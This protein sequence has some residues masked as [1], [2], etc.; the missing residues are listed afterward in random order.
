M[1]ASSSL[2]SSDAWPYSGSAALGVLETLG[3][4]AALVALDQ[5]LKTSNV[6]VLQAEWNDM[7]GSVIKVTGTTSDV[8][9]A[10][11]AGQRVAA[12]FFPTAPRNNTNILLIH[13]PDREAMRAILSPIEFSPLIEQ[14]VVKIPNP[15]D[16]SCTF[17][18]GVTPPMSNSF[19][20]G[21]IETQGF[22]AIFEA[23]D[24]ACKSAA[25]EVVGKEKLGGGYVT[26]VIKG[27]VAAVNAAV[28]AAKP[29]IEGLG[30]LIA[31]HV[32]ARPSPAAL[33]L[34]PK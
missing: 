19:A 15:S 26:I 23:I 25:V 18:H 5:M 1:N 8:E 11:Q 22:T 10:L 14:A 27:D 31:C 17:T 12:S 9:S 34:L 3:W 4:T 28:E 20:L 30:K 7:L 13:N 29:K 21:F 2:S 6:Q 16:S 33:V 24:T 32:I